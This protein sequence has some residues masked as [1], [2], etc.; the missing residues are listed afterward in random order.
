MTYRS[1]GN[2][3]NRTRDIPTPDEVRAMITGAGA[4]G[5][6]AE[7]RYAGLPA[8][9][10]PSPDETM[11]WLDCNERTLTES[12]RL[13]EREHRCATCGL[14]GRCWCD[15]PCAFCKFPPM[16][17]TEPKAEVS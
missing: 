17:P 1:P 14:Q 15:Q 3:P 12:R 9:T 5:F 16:H 8:E 4:D 10:P 2:D 11:V 7:N 13:A 6:Q